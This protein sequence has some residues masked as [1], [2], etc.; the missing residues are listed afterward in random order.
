MRRLSSRR[1]VLHRLIYPTLL[2]GAFAVAGLVLL[3]GP[4]PFPASAQDRW[5][6]AVSLGVAGLIALGQYFTFSRLATV[7]LDGQVL[8]VKAR[9]FV[10]R[11]PLTAIRDV[12]DHRLYITR[13]IVLVLAEG[14]C[15][16]KEIWFLPPLRFIWPWAR[17]PMSREL[18]ALRRD[19]PT[20][21]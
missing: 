14:V 1:T 2:I 5:F 9:R 7:D 20:A 4:S 18:D 17:H 6:G 16:V 21:A 19:R 10:G 11:L 13:T 8:Q 3:I 12:E 15:P